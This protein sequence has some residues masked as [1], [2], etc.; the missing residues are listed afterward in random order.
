IAL[1]TFPL[2]VATALIA[3]LGSAAYGLAFTFSFA[4]I[5]QL[6]VQG[7]APVSSS[8]VVV[9][10]VYL[11]CASVAVPFGLY[12]AMRSGSIRSFVQSNPLWNWTLAMIMGCCAMAA[13]V[14]YGYAGTASHHLSPNVSFA[15]FMSFLVLGSSALGILAGE[16]RRYSRKAVAGL[17]LSSTGLVAAACLLSSK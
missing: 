13:V 5:R 2:I 8:L 11:G 15:V 16:T 10:P 4:T 9:L 1:R 14:L 3:G 12:L 6:I 7:V 17:L